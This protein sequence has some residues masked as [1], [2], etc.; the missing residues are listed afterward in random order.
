V[1]RRRDL[2]RRRPDRPEPRR[3]RHEQ[4]AARIVVSVGIADVE[5]A[6]ALCRR[7]ES[8]RNGLRPR[9][10]A[11][12]R[13]SIEGLIERMA[14]WLAAADVLVHSTGGLTILEARMSACP[15]ISFGWG[16]G[17][18]R[19]PNEAFRRFGL[20]RLADSDD[21]LRD[22]LRQALDEPRVRHF[23]F[24]ALP[25]AASVVLEQAGRNTPAGRHE[26]VGADG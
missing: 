25:S 23:D 7:N 3:P 6:V 15:A 11:Q 22:A 26:K 16:R 18:V 12:P 14:D 19:D 8:L 20:A 24:P 17:H 2:R 9:Y 1:P 4:N 5:L 13:R 10:A 21:E